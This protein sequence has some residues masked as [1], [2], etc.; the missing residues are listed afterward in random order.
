MTA[1]LNSQGRPISVD[2]KCWQ[3]AEAFMADC[4]SAKPTEI[5]DLAEA[6][7]FQCEAAT[8]AVDARILAEAAASASPGTKRHTISGSDAADDDDL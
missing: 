7:Q 8:E 4:L 2:E 5:A 6:I 1:P 3:L